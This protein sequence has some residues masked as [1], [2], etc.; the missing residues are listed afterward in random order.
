V[1]RLAELTYPQ[2]EA[3]RDRGPVAVWPL[4][5]IEPHGPH[6]PLGTDT[7]ISVGICERA[8]KRI[9]DPPVVVLP[10]LGL[11]VTRYGAAFPGAIGISASTLT[12]VV[13]D[14]AAA[15]KRDGFSRL[16]LVNSH[17]EPE[18]VAT[19]RAAAEQAGALY[20]DLVRRR[21]A[22]RLTDEFRR[23]SCHAGRYET[24]LVLADA[25]E[26]IDAHQAARLPALDVNMPAEIAAGHTDFLAM[27]MNRAYCG[28]PAE[29]SAAEGE[30]TFE[31][32]TEMLIELIRA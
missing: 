27:G 17:F 32:L 31:T 6:A 1:L 7:M 8:A 10:A 24:S 21:Y 16:V 5:A 29:A 30:E 14:V 23:G 3:L 15:L 12:S 11:G 4:G 20:L 13:L 18:Q 2:L 26:L 25:P 22:E 19:L 28:A 9:E